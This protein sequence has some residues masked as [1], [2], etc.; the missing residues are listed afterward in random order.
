M[1]IKILK[2]LKIFE[3]LR[4]CET[5]ETL[6]NDYAELINRSILNDEKHC[7]VVIDRF[8]NFFFCF[9]KIIFNKLC[10]NF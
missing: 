8:M 1:L 3:L 6:I 4:V 2:I 7:R 9:S 10:F 5:E